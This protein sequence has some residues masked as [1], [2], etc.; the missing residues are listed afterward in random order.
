MFENR[1]ARSHYQ[2]A[3]VRRTYTSA[4]RIIRLHADNL[5]INAMARSGSQGS[6]GARWLIPFAKNIKQKTGSTANR[7]VLLLLIVVV[8]SA[9]QYGA[10]QSLRNTPGLEAQLTL[11]PVPEP[12]MR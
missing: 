8:N 12:S 5:H 2:R 4:L 6:F 1:L 7:I 11:R 9:A 3:S 10:A